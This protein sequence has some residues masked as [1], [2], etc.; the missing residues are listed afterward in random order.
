MDELGHIRGRLVTT[1][2][3]RRVLGVDVGRPRIGAYWDA[4]LRGL[5][6]R[7]LRGVRLVISG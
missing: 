5:V 6:T 7:G 1:E 4:P 3:E 2:G